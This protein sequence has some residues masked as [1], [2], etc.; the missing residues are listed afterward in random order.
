MHGPI[1]IQVA[2]GAAGELCSSPENY[3]EALGGSGQTSDR[4]KGVNETVGRV[5][6]CPPLGAHRW[7]HD[8]MKLCSRPEN[9]GP[10]RNHL[11]AGHIGWCRSSLIEQG[12]LEVAGSGP[13]AIAPALA[14]HL[15]TGHVRSLA[16]IYSGRGG[17]GFLA[18]VRIRGWD[19]VRV[20]SGNR[21]ASGSRL[22]LSN[23]EA[24]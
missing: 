4:A 14:V 6:G 13:L 15:A 5:L 21:A 9:Y 1:S 7:E 10:I 12:Q 16:A 22:S 3:G 19:C 23:Q 2:L 18:G 8:R 20:G 17:C 24:R 11:L